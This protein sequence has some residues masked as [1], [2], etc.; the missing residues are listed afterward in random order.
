MKPF[1]ETGNDCSKAAIFFFFFWN[2]LVN[3][4][5]I[6]TGVQDLVIFSLYSFLVNGSNVSV[7]NRR[8][9]SA[10]YLVIFST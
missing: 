1:S 6:P 7:E 2:V 9:H 3:S 10:F 4:V 8:W 5:M